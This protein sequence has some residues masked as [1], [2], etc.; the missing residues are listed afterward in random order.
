M[1][2]EWLHD[3]E[4]TWELK[5][6]LDLHCWDSR[7]C[8]QCDRRTDALWAE[9]APKWDK[10]VFNWFFNGFKYITYPVF[11]HFQN[12]SNSNPKSE[13]TEIY[14]VRRCMKPK[15]M[16]SWEISLFIPSRCS[17]AQVK[18]YIGLIYIKNA[19]FSYYWCLW[20]VWGSCFVS[21]GHSLSLMC[22]G[23]TGWWTNELSYRDAIMHLVSLGPTDGRTD[24]LI[25]MRGCI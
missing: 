3:D 22:D 4:I 25:E 2:M 7:W 1:M 15:L 24:P 5:I 23:L 13:L 18:P 10:T 16:H 9:R 14:H 11:F 19:T 17:R 21:G 8:S 20:N 6:F 12:L